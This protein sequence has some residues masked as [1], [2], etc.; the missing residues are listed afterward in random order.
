[1]NRFSVLKL[2][3]VSLACASRDDARAREKAWH[4]PT[5]PGAHLRELAERHALGG[6]HAL[7]LVV[8]QA[9]ELLVHLPVLQRVVF[10]AELR[11]A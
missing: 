11:V 8:E 9:D 7:H 6:K 5:H 1:M 10:A 3:V 4:D 2:P